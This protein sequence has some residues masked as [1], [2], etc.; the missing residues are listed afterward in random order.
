MFFGE[1]FIDA[2]LMVNDLKSRMEDKTARTYQDFW[3]C[4]ALAHTACTGSLGVST[5]YGMI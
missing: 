2:F 4:A 1:E 5:R 3:I